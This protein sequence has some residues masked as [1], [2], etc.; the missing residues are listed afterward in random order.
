MPLPE[1]VKA[2]AFNYVSGV[3]QMKFYRRNYRGC[4][5]RPIQAKEG[6]VVSY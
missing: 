5:R 6:L 3:N 4:T 1:Q 2:P